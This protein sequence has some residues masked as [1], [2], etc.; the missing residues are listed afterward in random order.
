MTD[1][2]WRM[3]NNGELADYTT[4][5]SISYKAVIC[6]RLQQTCVASVQKQEI[7]TKL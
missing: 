3:L 5:H 2:G 6:K 4:H 1:V 7:H